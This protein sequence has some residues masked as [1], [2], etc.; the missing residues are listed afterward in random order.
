MSLR[1]QNFSAL[2]LFGLFFGVTFS[3]D[4]AI[5]SVPVFYVLFFFTALL[6]WIHKIPF[7]ISEVFGQFF[8]SGLF[9]V[10][11][12]AN[13]DDV[14]FYYNG[15]F[16]AVLYI[17]V[18]PVIPFLISRYGV[19][20]MSAIALVALGFYGLWGLFSGSPRVSLVFGPNVYY[21]ILGVLLFVFFV[22][23]FW[24]RK[25]S[26]AP[27]I[28]L[29][30]GVLSLMATGSRGAFLII[31]FLF[32]VVGVKYFSDQESRRWIGPLW[33]ILFIAP[34]VFYIYWN[35]ISL[36][37]WRLAYF[38]LEN[39]SLATRI[40]FIEGGKEFISGASLVDLLFGLGSDNSVFN[41]YPHNVVIEFAVYHGALGLFP[42]M[43]SLIFAS[44]FLAKPVNWTNNIKIMFL[45]LSP[46]FIG[47]QFSGSL[48]ESFPIASL[49]GFLIGKGILIAIATVLDRKYS[50]EPSR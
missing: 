19:S 40:S 45:V 23:N 7:T 27:L 17:N 44:A 15:F 33:L 9:L 35:L 36:L 38:S 18:L 21:R 34:T 32:F 26:Y 29:F 11:M 1:L 39:A 41:F 4:Y 2:A 10:L 25:H 42:V 47:S 30:F 14:S 28:I 13:S 16:F 8:L 31:L 48:L 50:V 49:G 12:I 37:F 5:N 22:S 24:S 20:S 6:R 46:I 3:G 43:V